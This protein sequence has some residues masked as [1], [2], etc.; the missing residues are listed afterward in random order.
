MQT[1]TLILLLLLC[2]GKLFAQTTEK[3]TPA[4]METKS[5]A[6]V[7][8]NSDKHSITFDVVSKKIAPTDNPNLIN[9]PYAQ[10]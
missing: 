9:S 4:L 1:R 7:V 10:K 2:S 5:G 3:F 8:Y 6:K